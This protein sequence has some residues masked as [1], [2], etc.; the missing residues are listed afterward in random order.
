M[1]KNNS[2]TIKIDG[3]NFTTTPGKT[4]LQVARDNGIEIPTLCYDSRLNPYGSCLLCV[5]EVEGAPKLLLS[6]ATEVREGMIIQTQNEKIRRARKTALDLLLSNHFA[7]C[8]GN[9]YEKCPANV[10][11]QG[12]LAHAASGNYAEAL[13]L[14]MKTN[15]LPLVCGRVC[16]RYCEANCR[17]Q[18]VE[19]SVAVNF[20]KRYIADLEKD[21]LPKPAATKK[22]G[23]K[24]AVIGGGPSGLTA[25]YFL[26]K[27]GHSVKI[28]DAQPYL[29]GMIRW[30]IPDYRLP[31]ETLDKEIAY[32]TSHGIET[33]LN[34]KLGT[35]FTIDNLKTQGFEAIY[36]AL[37]AWKAKKMGVKN[38]ETEGVWG[39]INFLERVKKE[40]APKLEGHV[41]VVG[42]G[43]T[44][45]DAAR[46]AVR[47]GP[48][49]VSI[50][51]RRTREEM[52]ADDVEI[53]DALAEG[54]EIKYLVAPLEIVSENGKVSAIKCQ[55]MKLGDPDASGRRKPVAVEGSE[56]HIAC[57]V[58]IA[59][60]GQDCD[61]GNLSNKS[62]GE[63]KLTKWGT[64]VVDD[65]TLA[66]EAK[67]I[68]A[69]G[70]I[71]TGPLAAI[72]AIG[73]GR[74]AAEVIGEY[75]VTGK[76]QSKPTEFL[77]KKQNLDEIPP[78]WFEKV[79]KIERAKMRQTEVSCR[80]KCFD[81][82]DIGIS[83][84]QVKSETSKCMS[85][86]CSSVFTCDLKKYAGE[87]NVEQ[88][89][90]KG[91]AKKLE[92]DTR[93]PD[94]SID[95]NKCILCGRC[96]RLCGE[97]IGASALGFVNRGFE[98]IVKPAL[99]KPL[100]DTT[101]V[102]CGNCIETCPTGAIDYHLPFEKPGPW[103]TVPKESVCNF[104]GVGCEV[105][106]NKASNKTWYVSSK[107]KDSFTPGLVCSKGRFAHSFIRDSKRILSARTFEN[108]NLHTKSIDEAS[109]E[110][111][112]AIRSIIK[113]NG[114]SGIAV[115]VSPKST[116]EE[117]AIIREIAKKAGIKNIGSLDVDKGMI[118]AYKVVQS[119]KPLVS[120]DDIE[121]A[122]YIIVSGFNV[123]ETN[124]VVAFRIRQ[125]ILNQ[126]KLIFIGSKRNRLS[127]IS[128]L[129]INLDEAKIP[130]IF[131][132]ILKKVLVSRNSSP[133]SSCIEKTFISSLP[134]FKSVIDKTGISAE[135][136]QRLSDIISD[137][138]KNVVF[139]SHLASEIPSLANQIRSIVNLLDSSSRTSKKYNGLLLT[140]Q[141]SNL[142]GFLDINKT[143]VPSEELYNIINS[144]KVQCLLS[145]GENFGKVNVQYKIVFD[146]L[147]TDS[148]A[149]SQLV[150][151]YLPYSE[152]N[153]SVTSMDNVI[154]KF[155]NVFQTDNKK[156][157]FELL[158][159]VYTYLNSEKLSFEG[160]RKLLAEEIPG[161][162]QIT[163]PDLMKIRIRPDSAHECGLKVLDQEKPANSK[164]HRELCSLDKYSGTIK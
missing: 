24:V 16:V 13:E 6:C 127:D 11:V 164:H 157:N 66:S 7:D 47:C 61:P 12:Y 50:L 56:T 109:S 149:T 122:D 64:I 60:I 141:H 32:I 90:F 154:R 104:C 123:D 33:E 10:D 31:R 160:I 132:A 148:T 97:I 46:T 107:M 71:V 84:D 57:S 113:K 26:A 27:Q 19:S 4:I 145:Y 23:K 17:R 102:S 124:P 133:C 76:V 35:D 55:Q 106:F 105:V 40:G 137:K 78:S 93:H 115:L 73:A 151:P 121:S 112:D 80:V 144:G 152:N 54:V 15:P 146:A 82:V 41:V 110:V 1:Q 140:G 63:I 21:K 99:D 58:I 88:Q 3:K 14:I 103:M 120:V 142:M 100:Q 117:I 42:G 94:I 159:L 163:D 136:L 162:S 126:K 98:T 118:D 87:Y 39:G 135:N 143:I 156:S 5:V 43:N 74:R 22:T 85:C 114:S 96:V 29:G 155:V 36:L 108:G 8:R 65:K 131:S 38:E 59:A 116:N 72:D 101:C 150:I 119:K 9:C 79:Q 28:I 158:G 18:N 44:A 129:F 25:A 37:G 92:V 53:E 20:I 67:G 62:Y 147:E 51:Y 2:I 153:G 34:K 95:P 48:S 130:D 139:V 134:E 70:D 52:P 30:G 138:S 86:G 83:P 111:S 49:K 45:V 125:A 77:S 81:E 89:K 75:L 128:E 69:G 91:K 161:Y 68:F